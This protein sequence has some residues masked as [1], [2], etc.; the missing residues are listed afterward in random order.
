MDGR[1]RRTTPAVVGLGIVLAYCVVYLARGLQT[2][3]GPDLPV[4]IWW[5][6]RASQLGFSATYTGSRPGTIAPLAA[7]AHA[8]GVPISTVAAV[9]GPVLVVCIAGAAMFVV[10]AA[11]RV[12]RRSST[13]VAVIVAA[14]LMNATAGYLAALAFLALLTAAVGVVAA[15][16]RRPA[17]STKATAVVALA[18]AALAHPI[19]SGVAVAVLGGGVVAVALGAWRGS[20]P[21]AAARTAVRTAIPIAIP[22]GSSAIIAAAVFLLLRQHP[23]PP[24]D[25]SADAIFRRTG[26][27][28]GIFRE[29]ILSYLPRLVPVAIGIVASASALRWIVGRRESETQFV[30][31]V[32]VAWVGLT[33][34]GVAV[35]LLGVTFPGHRLIGLCLPLPV[36]AGVGIGEMIRQRGDRYARARVDVTVLT[37]VALLLGLALT[38]W[39]TVE[40]IASKE[41][42][43]A[44]RATASWFSASPPGTV[45]VLVAQPPAMF[46]K[47]WALGRVNVLRDAMPVRQIASVRLFGGNAAQLRGDIE[48]GFPTYSPQ[49]YGGSADVLDD[50]SVV[51]A[52]ETLDRPAFTDV[53]PTGTVVAPGVAVLETTARRGSDDRVP[54]DAIETF[55]PWVP[56]VLAPLVL[57]GLA[58]LGWPWARLAVRG[59]DASAWSIAPSLGLAA[60]SACSMAVAVVGIRLDVAGAVTATALA[61]GGSAVAW[62]IDRRSE[63]LLSADRT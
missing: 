38:Q 31:G 36:A 30:L 9:L 60:V 54:A 15:D 53:A 59:P 20:K 42:V 11:L 7:I 32:A 12:D 26:E 2:G 43:R 10:E 34:I 58:V 6:R 24:L 39:W 61:V 23:A 1:N 25:T 46:E 47:V 44:A 17:W 41:E 48:R 3:M 22:L 49:V 62:R 18:C 56:L 40:P 19:L 8:T 28:L 63:R 52:I 37:V 16:V 21:A 13:L 27:E 55:S 35:L 4:Y 5:A 14:Y 57:L 33:A 45:A 51:F 50:R 29:R